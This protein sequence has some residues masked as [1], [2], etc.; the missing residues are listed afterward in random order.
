[1]KVFLLIPPNPARIGNLW[2]D[3]EDRHSGESSG[4]KPP[5]TAASILGLLRHDIDRIEIKAL[6]A[7]VSN[8]SFLEVKEI[9]DGYRPD[10]IICL[11]AA[12]FINEDRKY[13][14]LP[15]PTISVLCPSSVD[16][17]EAIK[18]FNL[19]TKYFTKW[20]IENTICSAIREFRDK[21]K[22]ESTP[23]MVIQDSGRLIDTGQP[24]SESVDHLPIPAFDYFP[25]DT[26]FRHQEESW[27][28]EFGNKR[29]MWLISSKGCVKR[30]TFCDSATL[31]PIAKTPEQVVNEVHYYVTTYNCRNF[32]FIDSEFPL[33]MKRAKEI[34][35]GIINEGLNIRWVAHNIV[36]LVDEELLSLMKKAGCMKLKYG[37]ESG[38]E[39]ILK[40]VNKKWSMDQARKAFE[41]TRKY[42]IQIQAN[43][44]VGFLG[45]DKASLK[46]TLK[47]FKALRPDIACNSILFPAPNSPMYEQFKKDKLLLNT[48]WNQYHNPPTLL[49]K[50]DTYNSIDEIKKACSWLETK[51][52]AY[53]AFRNLFKISDTIPAITRFVNLLKAY[54]VIRN[55]L[56]RISAMNIL[57][58]KLRKSLL[59]QEAGGLE[60]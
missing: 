47:A 41:L 45:E 38:D 52:N 53:L 33:Y 11:V 24:A 22:I 9:I 43:F 42:G 27:H 34:C 35:R 12:F 51:I 2:S 49:F 36:E 30:C 8:L 37:L 3:R 50:H 44:M 18:L 56:K 48:D 19:K 60:S 5:Y 58:S 23:G 15:Y 6:D 25:M 57:N 32:D 54:P 13:A 21:G 16:P 26:Y 55:S 14:E 40:K 39:A 59:G 1:M 29:F 7:R 17:K 46:K 20:E 10:I 4:Y 31:K 28:W